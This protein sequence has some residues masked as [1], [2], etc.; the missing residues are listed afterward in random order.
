LSADQIS[1]ISPGPN[2]APNHPLI[3]ANDLIVCGSAS[4][5]DDQTICQTAAQ[6]LYI[7]DAASELLASRA[8]VH[9][10]RS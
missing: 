2:H 7:M 5:Q 4:D 6:V 10:T 1:E 3:F 9:F 8:S